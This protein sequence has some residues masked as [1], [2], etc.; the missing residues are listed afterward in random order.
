MSETEQAAAVEVEKTEDVPP[1]LPTSEPPKDDEPVT[2]EETKKEGEEKEEKKEEAKVEP[3][4]D[5]REDPIGWIQQQLPHA[6]HQVNYHVLDWLQN[7]VIEDETKRQPL[8]GKNG[9]VTRNQFLAFLR[10]GTLLASLAKK[11]G[12][13][14]ETIHEGDA[15]KNNKENQTANIQ[16]FA[17]WAKDKLGLPEEQVMTAADLLEKGKAGYP[18]VFHSVWQAGTQAVEKFGA[19]SS[20]DVD[21]VVAAA[22]AA[23]KTNIIQTILNFFKRARPSPQLEKKAAMEAEEAAKAEANKVEEVAEEE[24]KKVEPAIVQQTPVVE[25]S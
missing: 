15:V 7:T 16:A 10:D 13:G 19:A 1:A 2:K 25:A 12:A 18:Q 3:P 24:C 21:S 20:L 6:V 14:V 11:M 22:A 8:P 23:V 9:A 17:D 4:K 5:P